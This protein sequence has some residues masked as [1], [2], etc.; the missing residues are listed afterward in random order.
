MTYDLRRLRLKGLIARI[1]RSHT[2]TL[3]PEGQRFA[4]TYTKLGRRLIPPLLA[5]DQPPAPTELRQALATIDRH[6]TNYLDHARLR[7]AA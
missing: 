3:T 4:I 2:Y 1:E 7:T 6:V 5:G